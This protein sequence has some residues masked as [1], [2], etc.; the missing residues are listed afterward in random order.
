[1]DQTPTTELESERHYRR[2][3]LINGLL[4]GLALAL[5]IWLPGVIRIV[6]VPASLSTASVILATLVL[7]AAGALAGWLSARWRRAG[8]VFITW[9][10]A[11]ALMSLAVGYQ[12]YQ[13]RSF[14][15]WLLDTRFWGRALFPYYGGSL[16]VLLIAGFFIFLA[17]GLL[18]LLQ[19]YRLEALQH[20]REENGRL[21]GTAWRLLLWPLPLV[22]AAG[23][24][25]GNLYGNPSGPIQEVH[26]AITTV[27]NY[28]GD[29]IEL[30]QTQRTG[31]TALNPVRDQ[32]AGDYTLQLGEINQETSITIVVAHFD[33]GAWINCRL[34]ADQLNFCYDAAPPYTVGFASLIS[35]EAPPEAVCRN[36]VPRAGEE[37]LSWL[38]AR[39]AAL[40]PE[41]EIAY[42]QQRGRYVLMRAAARD[43][44]AA[45][46]CWFEGL[47]PVS[48]ECCHE[49]EP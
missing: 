17:L 48:L 35:G 31:L 9:L 2:M 44:Q 47:S 1:M 40:G 19:P 25:T 42:V 20:E 30:E 13:L 16:V 5:G 18:A 11:A 49:V 12:S 15:T 32:L 4:L 34:I 21:T 7:V 38:A 6:R 37:S 24:I 3:G 22:F 46:E 39:R 41:P 10:A 14:V 43:G 36:C 45:I 33:N 8:P 23:L 27:Q 26:R 28:E 29:L